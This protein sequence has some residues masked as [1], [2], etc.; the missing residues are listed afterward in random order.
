MRGFVGGANSRSSRRP[1]VLRYHRQRVH[2]QVQLGPTRSPDRGAQ[3]DAGL[4]DVVLGPRPAGKA[5]SRRRETRPRRP[6]RVNIRRIRRI[7]VIHRGTIDSVPAAPSVRDRGA[8][9]R[10]DALD[11][12]G[13]GGD[14]ATQRDG[15]GGAGQRGDALAERRE[16][17]RRRRR[18]QAP[19]PSAV[20]TVECNLAHPKL[21]EARPFV[22]VFVCERKPFLVRTQEAFE[23]TAAD[24]GSR[25]R[26]GER[27]ARVHQC[28]VLV[29]PAPRQ[30][31][32]RPGPIP[33]GKPVQRT[34]NNERAR[35]RVV[36]DVRGERRG[37]ER[38]EG[39]AV[40]TGI[41]R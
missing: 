38:A 21:V 20:I 35:R 8:C 10:A 18:R 41:T 29:A 37:G 13:D 24:G 34:Q 39:A 23:Q 9:S 14:A 27:H 40:S 30:P 5:R 11:D 22:F 32:Q 3:R 1:R 36:R 6:D 25:V 19:C 4:N 15:C 17:P 26:H 16:H 33:R 2:R 12:D 7:V 31:A 28:G